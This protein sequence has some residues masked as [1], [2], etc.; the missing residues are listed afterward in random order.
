MVVQHGSVMHHVAVMVAGDDD[1]EFM[2][3]INDGFCDGDWSVQGREII[4][5]CVAVFD[6]GLAFPVISETGCL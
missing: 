6:S 5:C 4:R 2:V 3:E 1:G